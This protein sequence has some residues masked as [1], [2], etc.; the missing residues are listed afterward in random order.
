[1]IQGVMRI[2]P[3]QYVL[4]VKNRPEVQVVLRE[5]VGHSSAD[6]TLIV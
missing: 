6:G 3:S 2:K 5:N 1:M 4:S